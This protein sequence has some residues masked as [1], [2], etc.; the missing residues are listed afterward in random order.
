MRVP[1]K[2]TCRIPVEFRGNMKKVLFI[3]YFFPPIGGPGVA[4]SLKFAKYLPEFG[5]LPIVISADETI[6]YVKDHSLLEQVPEDVEVHRVGHRKGLSEEMKYL[7]AKLRLAFDFPGKYKYWH[8]PAYR[9]AREI[10]QKEKIDLILTTSGPYTSHLIAMKLKKEFGIPWVADFRDPWLGNTILQVQFRNTLIWPLRKLLQS[11]IAGAERRILATA[12]RTVVVSWR[13]KEQLFKLY[14]VPE[15]M[16]EVITNGYDES[17]FGQLSD[18]SLYPHKPTIAFLGGFQSLEY[19][20]VFLKFLNILRELNKEIEVLCI[21]QA[22]SYMQKAAMDNLTCI[23]SLPKAK[24]LTLCSGGDFLFLIVPSHAS[25][26]I[27]GKIFEYLRL[28]K[29]ILGICPEDGDAARVIKEAGAG[30]VLSHDGERMKQQ[31]T[32]IIGKW[33]RGEFADFRPN[34]EYVTQFERREL[35]QKLAELLDEVA[36]I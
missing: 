29:P 11:K 27:P 28:R 7:R 3:A 13:H 10:L 16:V 33:E 17:Q 2:A 22:A 35:T 24:A 30:Y 19:R 12:D 18:F 31:L 4:R 32:E 1:G 36:G 23:Y 5:W 21:G 14:D 9:K 34:W 25:W 20:G 26:M 8:R 15:D 6:N